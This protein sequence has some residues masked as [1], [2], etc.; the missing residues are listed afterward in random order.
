MIKLKKII[1]V[2]SLLIISQFIHP[3]NLPTYN[4]NNTAY[5]LNE[6]TPTTACKN[7]CTDTTPIF[8][9]TVITTDAPTLAET[10]AP[11]ETATDASTPTA[12]STPAP[13]SI[14]TATFGSTYTPTFI[15]TFATYPYSSTNTPT[16]VQSYTPTIT[17]L[18]S[19]TVQPTNTPENYNVI[20]EGWFK[21]ERN[22]FNNEFKID[23]YEGYNSK[24]I[25]ECSTNPN[26]YFKM[27][28]NTNTKYTI[29]VYKPN[30]KYIPRVYNLSLL[31]KFSIGSISK[32]EQ[33]HWGDLNNDEIIN[34]ADILMVST[35][36]GCT[37]SSPSYNQDIDL[38]LDGVIN[39]NDI[40]KLSNIFSITP[41]NQIK[42]INLQSNTATC[43][44]PSGWYSIENTLLDLKSYKLYINGSL[45]FRST[46]HANGVGSSLNINSGTLEI[47]NDLNF[48]QPGYNDSLIMTKEEGKLIIGK[49]FIFATA[50]DHEGLLSAGTIVLKGDYFN[51]NDESNS[52]AFY[53]T[54]EHKIMLLGS[55]RKVIKL[56]SDDPSKNRRVNIIVVPNN[57]QFEI[58]PK[59]AYNNILS[60]PAD[61]N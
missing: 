54:C 2:V 44:D 9:P 1:P 26:G 57:C 59:N 55:T 45:V 46:T 50:V 22:E 61:T 35:G 58:W 48:G 14:S 53:A 51:I 7:R 34:I 4:L 17:P 49:G 10:S 23:V 33:M 11:T 31:G 5:S 25:I 28:F 20:V 27:Y 6:N 13:T 47:L 56:S 37:S 30:S 60:F 42:A 52:K 32:P 15:P 19:A 39:I 16:A 38:N 12:L 24:P 29:K 36:F 43:Y 18:S 40:M 3:I 41:E 21:G 8:T